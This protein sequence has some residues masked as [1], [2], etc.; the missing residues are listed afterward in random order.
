[1]D[2]MD[3]GCQKISRAIRSNS[4]RARTRLDANHP[5]IRSPSRRTIRTH[6]SSHR[7]WPESVAPL[8]QMRIVYRPKLCDIALSHAALRL[9]PFSINAEFQDVIQQGQ[10][11]VRLAG[12]DQ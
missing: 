6:Q 10:A 2:R 3:P 9:E 7:A 8:N 5:D 4:K 1:M 11:L 12:I